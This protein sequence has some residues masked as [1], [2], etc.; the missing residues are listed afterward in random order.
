M[1]EAWAPG[2]DILFHFLKSDIWIL[3]APTINFS[4]TQQNSHLLSSEVHYT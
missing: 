1:F 4:P 3:P 2:L